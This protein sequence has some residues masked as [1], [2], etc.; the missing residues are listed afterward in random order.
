MSQE[1]RSSMHPIQIQVSQ[2]TYHTLQKIAEDTGEP[3]EAVLDHAVEDYR[4]RDFLAGL[5]AD[6]AALRK[7][8]EAWEEEQRERTAWDATLAD[9]LGKE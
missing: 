3:M 7:D 9:G 1:S 5:N 6:F 4:R 8:P 2:D